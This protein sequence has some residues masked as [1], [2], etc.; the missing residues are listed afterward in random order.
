M[1]APPD[2]PKRE[3]SPLVI[4]A[5]IFLAL[6]VLYLLSYGPAVWLLTHGYSDAWDFAR[7]FYE[8]IGWLRRQSEWF[9]ALHDWYISF[10]WD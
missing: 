2:T 7:W 10:F 4:A 8:P 3:R 5:A 6:P 9:N 1:P